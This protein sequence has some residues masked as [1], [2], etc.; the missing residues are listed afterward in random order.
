MGSNDATFGMGS[1]LA[2]VCACVAAM[3]L[4]AACSPAG[5]VLAEDGSG[6]EGAMVD[7]AMTAMEEAVGSDPLPHHEDDGVLGYFKPRRGLDGKMTSEVADVSVV[8]ADV[9]GTAGEVVMDVT[10]ENHYLDGSS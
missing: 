4:A 9:E 2:C 8:G 10:R 1:V 5:G 7:D 3:L 6:K